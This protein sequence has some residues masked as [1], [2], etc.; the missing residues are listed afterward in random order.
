M[1][2]VIIHQFEVG[3]MQ[4]FVYLIEETATKKAAVV[5]PAWD[6]PKIIDEVNTR[7]LD[8]TSLYLTHGHHD[9]VNGVEELLRFKPIPIYLSAHET[10]Y[11]TPSSAE[12]HL[13][14]DHD[15]ITLGTLDIA[16]IHT[17]G[18]T[19]GGQCFL[20][21][22]HL[23][24]GDTVFIN[25]CG[26]CDL[27]ASN[28]EDMYHSLRK[29]MTL[30]DPTVIYPGHN[31]YSAATDTLGNQKQTNPFMASENLHTFLR[32]RMGIKKAPM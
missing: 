31:Y 24:S 22:N 28:P 25:G 15:H 26:R 29:I 8:L 1:K 30:P 18:H 20:V 7:N 17:P 27:P 12:T 2:N 13:L 5:D 11:S 10:I 21:E 19:P 16:V 6:V 32:L 4:N 14:K 23:I 3:P 9:H